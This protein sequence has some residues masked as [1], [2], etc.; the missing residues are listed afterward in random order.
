MTD[1]KKP[2]LPSLLDRLTDDSHILKQIQACRDEVKALEQ[3]LHE[4]SAIDPERAQA[5]KREIEKNNQYAEYLR[6]S[7]GS[8][9]SIR[10]SVKRDLSWLMNS[11]N[12]YMELK[13]SYE[14]SMVP[15]DAEKYPESSRSVLNY[16]LPDLTGR[17]S[18]SVQKKQLENIIRQALLTFEPRIMAES[19]NLNVIVED[20]MNDH[21]VLMFEI[22]A[23]LWAEPAPVQLQIR[24]QLDLETGG[25]ELV[26]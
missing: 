3:R 23:M 11:R 26:G 24:T 25:I 8:F 9:E 4:E 17:T 15:L 14:D 18:S 6:G 2:L 16:G 7:I 13:N 1:A 19:L 10:D 22:D 20:V 12:F 21:N 5:H